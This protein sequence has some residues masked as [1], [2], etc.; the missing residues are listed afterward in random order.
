MTTDDVREAVRSALAE[1]VTPAPRHGLVLF[2]G[3]LIGF[4]KSLVEL[5]TLIG[6]GVRLE[7]VQT[8][9]AERILDQELIGLL[10]MSPAN[11]RLTGS[12]DMLIVATL[13]QNIA[14]KTAHGVA[15]CLAS[16]LMNDYLLAGKPVVVAA[17]GA[18]PDDPDKQRWFG[19]IPAG[20]ARMMRENLST[21]RD[22][23]VRTARSGALAR[24]VLAAYER[25][26][27]ARISPVT[28]AFG[29]SRRELLC[30]LGAS[31]PRRALP[32][33]PRT[34]VLPAPAPARPAAAPARPAPTAG[35]LE[36][37]AGLISQRLVQRL[38][39]GSVLRVPADAKITA[40]AV[41][42]AAARSLTII[43]KD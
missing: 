4:E 14:A 39:V 32:P 31:G 33:D 19:S 22:F 1:L 15:D 35:T 10:P 7:F 24:T 27:N 42:T 23:G 38:P 9:S 6:E 3:A 2:T 18:D 34:A 11:G 17:S 16:N 29:M 5:A 30:R 20:Y 12:H 13:T 40:M 25:L 41:D 21:L 8:P 37:Q 28:K 26:E 43:R 36:I